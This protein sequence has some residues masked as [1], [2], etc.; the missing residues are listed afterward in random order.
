MRFID[1]ADT[2]N[3]HMQQLRESDPDYVVDVLQ[4]TTEEILSAFPHR[5]A[6][7]IENEFG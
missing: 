7:Y 6:M 1:S 4:L 2:D 5:A 3:F